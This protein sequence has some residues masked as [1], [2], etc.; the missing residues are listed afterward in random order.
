MWHEKSKKAWVLSIAFE[1]TEMER[2]EPYLECPFCK[3]GPIDMDIEENEK[4]WSEDGFSWKDNTL[5]CVTCNQ[6]FR[7]R[8]IPILAIEEYEDYVDPWGMCLACNERV[9]LNRGEFSFYIS[10]P[11]NYWENTYGANFKMAVDYLCPGCGMEGIVIYKALE[12]MEAI[13]D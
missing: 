13:N 11:T 10:R 8:F 2:I 1:R 9:K 12:K 3:L 6:L 5:Q 7:Q 4:G